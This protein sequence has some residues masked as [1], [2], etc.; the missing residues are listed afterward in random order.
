MKLDL[1][2]L[3]GSGVLRRHA[4]S[5]SASGV[6]RN[7]SSVGRETSESLSCVMRRAWSGSLLD[8]PPRF[9]I[10]VLTC[11]VS[12]DLWTGTVHCQLLAF[13]LAW[14]FQPN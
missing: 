10:P 12:L 14:Q 9:A 2:A 7:A 6:E 13:R 3:T 11:G 8:F 4:A 1:L 5:S